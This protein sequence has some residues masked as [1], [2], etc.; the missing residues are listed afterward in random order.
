[1]YVPYLGNLFKQSAL[2][3]RMILLSLRVILTNSVLRLQAIFMDL[4]LKKP[5]KYVNIVTLKVGD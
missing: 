4:V 1:M 3:E 5:I 2:I